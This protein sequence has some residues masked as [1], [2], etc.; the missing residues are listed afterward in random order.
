MPAPWNLY[1]ASNVDTN[2]H[3][4][5]EFFNLLKP[6]GT[7][8]LG[9]YCSKKKSFQKLHQRSVSGAFLRLFCRTTRAGKQEKQNMSQ[10]QMYPVEFEDYSTGT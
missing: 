10:E 3:V 5:K 4:E 7:I 1:P 6:D 2:V 9:C 8:P